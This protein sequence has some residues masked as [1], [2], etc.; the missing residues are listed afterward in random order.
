MAIDITG[1]GYLSQIQ[2]AVDLGGINAAELHRQP[3]ADGSSILDRRHHLAILNAV[4]AG[5]CAN[6]TV[7]DAAMINGAGS[8]T[9]ATS[10][11]NYAGIYA[12][13]IAKKIYD[14]IQLYNFDEIIT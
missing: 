3:V 9:A 12:R 10:N 4:H 5:L 2:Q 1:A 7:F 11:I 6:P 13:V 8:A 14:H